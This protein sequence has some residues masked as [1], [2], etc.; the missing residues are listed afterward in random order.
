MRMRPGWI[1]GLAL[2]LTG[3]GGDTASPVG[4]APEDLAADQVLFD[5][6]Q[7]VT[8]DGVRRARLEADTAFYHEEES[9]VELRGVHLVLF[10]E[11]GA[12]ISTVTS[13]EGE[14]DTRSEQMLARGNVVVVGQGGEGRLDRIETEELHYDP[15]TNRIWSDVET[16]FYRDDDR[17][18]GDS[19]TSD[20]T[21]SIEVRNPSGT[22]RGAELSF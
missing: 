18:R 12:R 9:R 3:C 22:L 17:G 7:N 6:V 1:A 19:F 13:R 15:S 11:A 10:D 2:V 14:I 5:L 16:W 4:D 20:G 21:R 8:T